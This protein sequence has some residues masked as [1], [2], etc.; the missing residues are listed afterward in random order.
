M[1]E[2]LFSAV[3]R[4]DMKLNFVDVGAR[5]GSFLLPEEYAAKCCLV[6]FEPNPAEYDKLV[7]GKT[8]AVRAGLREPAFRDRRYFSKALW[9]E[10]AE[11][12][13]TIP[14]GAGAV[15]LMGLAHVE[16]TRNLWREF[17][18]GVTYYDK[19]QVPTG[20]AAVQCDSLDNLWKGESGL[21][22]IL[23]L[24]VEGAECAVL[25]G[26]AELLQERRIL[27]IRSEFLLTPY[28]RD[29]VLLG[30]QQVLLDRLG[31]RLVALDVD[32]A[33]YCWK[34]TTIP[35]DLDRR[36]LYAGDA[37]YIVDPDLMALDVERQYRLGLACVA[38]GFNATGLNLIRASK[39]LSEPD[40]VAIEAT[41]AQKGIGRR[42]REMWESVPHFAYRVANAWR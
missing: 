41:A 14:R 6:G 19:V 36:F 40:I 16:M 32:H 22:D 30:H 27:L 12:D 23:K 28:Y 17:D 4:N 1:A 5:N 35:Q 10:T 25:E 7:N 33:S 37:F 18:R 15:T 26:A 38:F 24:D 8:D 31:Y 9:R 39:L 2:V 13:L 11:L 34:K 29:H 42:L 20:T 21:I 3:Q